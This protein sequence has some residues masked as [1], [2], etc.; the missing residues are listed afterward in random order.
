MR[1]INE[2]KEVPEKLYN[3]MVTENRAFFES[4]ANLD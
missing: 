1:M 2:M 3:A 4:R